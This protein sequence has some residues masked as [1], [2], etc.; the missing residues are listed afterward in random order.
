MEQ[1]PP[2]N[3]AITWWLADYTNFICDQLGLPHEQGDHLF[4]HYHWLTTGGPPQQPASSLYGYPT[5]SPETPIEHHSTH[6]HEQSSGGSP[7]DS[8]QN[9]PVRNSGS[10]TLPHE[11]CVKDEVNH[12]SEPSAMTAP[13]IGPQGPSSSYGQEPGQTSSDPC[14]SETNSLS[15]QSVRPSNPK[16]IGSVADYDPLWVEHNNVDP[17]TVN[18]FHTSMK[19]DTLF[20]HKVIKSGDVLTFP[21]AVNANGQ[22]IQTEAHLKVTASFSF[23]RTDNKTYSPETRS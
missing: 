21:V 23:C 12:L 15:M 6:S 4:Q 9:L 8:V 3:Q 22:N 20:T 17:D 1:Y 14:V 2:S 11:H 5:A 7:E 16:P 18:N 13:N 10:P 19:F